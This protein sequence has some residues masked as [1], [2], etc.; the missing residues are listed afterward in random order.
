M[1]QWVT[2]I[3]RKI[4]TAYYDWQDSRLVES[5]LVDVS[6][7]YA[8][9]VKII[10]QSQIRYMSPAVGGGQVIP[11]PLIM[12]TVKKVAVQLMSRIAP[13]VGVQPLSAPVG[14]V[15]HMQ[16][17]INDA[18]LALEI[19]SHA[20]QA[21]T[22]RLQTRFTPEAAQTLGTLNEIELE[23]ELSSMLAESIVS[24]IELEV[25]SNLIQLSKESHVA[26]PADIK[27]VSDRIN[28]LLVEINK[29]ANNIAGSTFR[30]CGNFVLTTPIGASLLE[31]TPT[32]K[33]NTN[34]RTDLST[35]M[36]IGTMIGTI[37]VYSTLSL[38]QSPNQ[39][40]IPFLVGYKGGSSEIDTGYVYMP[41][42]TLM[43]SLAVDPKTFQ[44]VAICMTRY[45]KFVYHKENTDLTSDYYRIVRFELPPFDNL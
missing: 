31:S 6:E 16:C 7:N 38:P 25:F 43:S 4:V 3:Y 18:A 11:K 33:K 21:S 30:G 37:S 19:I 24:E 27:L 14:Q 29:Q 22:H 9:A 41:Y 28:Y 35:T 10:L 42:V 34:P 40:E 15:F 36:L 20:V 26:V 45:G 23:A 17:S 44:P 32:F 13:F 8:P 5:L 1:K 39:S 12:L 2:K